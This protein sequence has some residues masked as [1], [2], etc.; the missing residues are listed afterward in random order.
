MGPVEAFGWTGSE[1]DLQM[2]GADH[3]QTPLALWRAPRRPDQP[4][5]RTVPEEG[6]VLPPARRES[7][8]ARQ[9]IVPV[10]HPLAPSLGAADLVFGV[11]LI[12]IA[13][14]AALVLVLP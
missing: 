7:G 5:S 3:E 1:R 9:G 12:L 10:G 14:G 13:I 4:G 8:A 2:E 11:V 6:R